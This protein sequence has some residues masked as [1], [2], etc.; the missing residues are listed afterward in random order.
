MII[1][2]RGVSV[3]TDIDDTIKI[4]NVL[5]KK[6]LLR[7]TFLRP[8]RA[9]PGMARLFAV[10]QARGAVFHYVTA[11]PW[12]IYE[13]L[14]GFTADNGFPEGV[15][16]MRS[17]GFPFN[18]T[19]LLDPADTVKIP[20]ITTLMERFPRHRF[21]LVGDSGERD[22]EIYGEI[23]RRFPGR[24]MAVYIRNVGNEEAGSPRL[25][26]AFR[27]IGS[28]RW[29]LFENADEIAREGAL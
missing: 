22:P 24:V 14:A 10:W 9:V 4:S 21:I 12:Q 8:Y 11:S 13:S 15:F 1:P 17:F 26:E 16:H 27:D 3:I 5:D 29:A 2:S 25:A 23:A 6:E 7:N 19:S 20:H 28:T 18:F